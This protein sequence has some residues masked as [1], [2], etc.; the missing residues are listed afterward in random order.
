V[1]AVK[2]AALPW[3]SADDSMYSWNPNNNLESPKVPI[4]DTTPFKEA[5]SSYVSTNSRRHYYRRPAVSSP[6]Y[7]VNAYWI[8]PATYYP[9]PT[10]VAASHRQAQTV[11]IVFHQDETTQIVSPVEINDVKKIKNV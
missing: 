3:Y 10:A 2:G 7:Q 9:P 4:F 6:S 11:V 5:P 1:V 8:R